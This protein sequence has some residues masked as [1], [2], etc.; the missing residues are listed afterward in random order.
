MESGATIPDRSGKKW[1]PTS[2]QTGLVRRLYFDYQTGLVRSKYSLLT[3][4]VDLEKNVCI[5]NLVE[6]VQPSYQTGLVSN[7]YLLLTRP[8]W[9][10]SL[11]GFLSHKYHRYYLALRCLER[12]SVRFVPNSKVWVFNQHGQ[13]ARVK[14][15]WTESQLDSSLGLARP[16]TVAELT[17]KTVAG[18][19]LTM[20]SCVTRQ[21]CYSAIPTNM[22]TK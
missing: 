21:A 12:M 15:L 8:V 10:N 20:L 17:V 11:K 22:P 5:M 16:L 4:L 9:Y 14:R 1:V 7:E 2:Y 19:R 13:R 18:P 6:K 3:R